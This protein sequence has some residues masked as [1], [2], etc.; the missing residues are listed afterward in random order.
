MR[1]EGREQGMDDFTVSSLPKVKEQVL[2][3]APL[4]NDG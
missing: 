4:L 3:H 2:L 1:N